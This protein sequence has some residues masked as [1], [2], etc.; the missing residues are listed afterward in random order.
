MLAQ[1]LPEGHVV[2]VYGTHGSFG[3]CCGT[4]RLPG[5]AEVLFPTGQAHDADHQVLLEGNQDLQGGVAPDIRVPLTRETVYAMFV[6]G[7]DVVL[8]RALEA[9]QGP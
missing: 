7:E 3:M 9:L 5:D 4:V 2:G 1:R 6:E 8:Q